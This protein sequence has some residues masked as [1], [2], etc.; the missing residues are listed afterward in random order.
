METKIKIKMCVCSQLGLPLCH[1]LGLDLGIYIKLPIR[2]YI[3][4][5]I[6]KGK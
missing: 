2:K 1:I 3:Y 6:Y 5:K 4:T